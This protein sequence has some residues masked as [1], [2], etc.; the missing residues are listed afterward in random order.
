MKIKGRLPYNVH[1][2]VG[3]IV[4]RRWP[5]PSTV[6][7]KFMLSKAIGSY[8][9]PT[10]VPVDEVGLVLQRVDLELN[11]ASWLYVVFSSGVGWIDMAC[12]EDV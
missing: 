2:D 5:R 7:S 11:D 8:A 12:L 3:D 1:M 9:Q 10:W 6:D 4:R